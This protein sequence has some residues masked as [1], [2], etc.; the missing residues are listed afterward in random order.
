MYT[1]GEGHFNVRR[2]GWTGDK[3]RGFRITRQVNGIAQGWINIRLLQH[4]QMDFGQQGG[5]QL[6]SFAI[7]LQ[8]GPGIC[9]PRQR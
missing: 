7:R 4:R 8:N 5:L 1:D 2:A 6:A 3:D 9:M